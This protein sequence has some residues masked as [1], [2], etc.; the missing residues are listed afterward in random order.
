MRPLAQLRPYLVPLYRLEDWGPYGP[1]TSSTCG[2]PAGDPSGPQKFWVRK[3]MGGLRPPSFWLGAPLYPFTP[4]IKNIY[5]YLSFAT[6]GTVLQ[7][8]MTELFTFEVAVKNV[9]DKLRGI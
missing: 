3:N 2:G 8:K 9:T 6:L 4:K 5:Q 1:P 7:W